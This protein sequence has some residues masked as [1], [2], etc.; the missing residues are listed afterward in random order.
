MLINI[1]LILMIVWILIIVVFVDCLSQFQI[2]NVSL[3]PVSR[4]NGQYCDRCNHV[5]LSRCYS[6]NL[7]QFLVGLCLV[8]FGYPIVRFMLT[9]IASDG[10]GQSSQVVI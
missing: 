4:V 8:T 1:T 3:N 2:M 6:L 7:V 10:L 5:C 9:L